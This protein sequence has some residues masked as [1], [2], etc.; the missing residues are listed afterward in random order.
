VKINV[1]GLLIWDNGATGGTTGT[2]ESYSTGNLD[3]NVNSCGIPVEVWPLG[4]DGSTA[5]AQCVR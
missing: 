4:T 3:D 1:N 2:N 5:A